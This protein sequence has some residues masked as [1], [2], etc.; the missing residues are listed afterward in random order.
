MQKNS[1][2][3]RTICFFLIHWFDLSLLILSATYDSTQTINKDFHFSEMECSHGGGGGGV[4][5]QKGEEKEI[6]EKRRKEEKVI[7]ESFG[8][9]FNRDHK[10][11]CY[12]MIDI[13]KIFISTQNC[14]FFFINII[15][16][17]K[18]ICRLKLFNPSGHNVFINI[19]GLF[20][21]ENIVFT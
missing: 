10:I 6:F 17:I 19:W 14:F 11:L 15:I 1:W 8:S 9:I 2:H 18:K 12:Y 16:Y 20:F 13:P 4:S 7:K 21:V 5:K 3:I